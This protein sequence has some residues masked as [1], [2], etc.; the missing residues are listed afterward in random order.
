MIMIIMITI[1]IIVPTHILLKE[2]KRKINR[3]KKIVNSSIIIITLAEI[4]NMIQKEYN[5]VTVLI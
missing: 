1:T 5:K 4:H 3:L 2:E